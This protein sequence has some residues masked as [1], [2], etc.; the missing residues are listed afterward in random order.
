MYTSTRSSDGYGVIKIH[1]YND[2]L[3]VNTDTAA[4]VSV[5]ADTVISIAEPI[6][7]DPQ[8]V[9]KFVKVHGT[10]KNSK[11]GEL[12]V[13]QIHFAPDKES[14]IM[15]TSGV[16]GYS[17]SLPSSE[18]YS[19]K[20]EAPGYI[21]I[22]EKLDIHT[23]EMQQLEMNFTLQP[24]EIGTTVNLKS[25]LFM[26]AKTD[27]L[28]ESYDELD[29][30]VSFLKTNPNIRIELSGHTD[31]RGV[32]DDNVRLS[33]QRVNA[34]KSYLVSKGIDA[35]RITGKGYGGTKPIASNDTEETRMMNRR[36]EFII[37][38]F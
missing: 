22:L 16:N 1:R 21:S 23:Y 6:R 11:T 28:P 29:L 32:H 15:S 19:I 13:A 12:I 37:K 9:N 14:K 36:V 2:P 27:L 7:P 17:A 38:K 31:N 20:I 30:V 18:M 33:Q 35:K 3:P 8:P 5:S 24:V 34:V 10:V 26:Q 25:V 4:L